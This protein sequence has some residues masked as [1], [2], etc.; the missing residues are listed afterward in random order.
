MDPQRVRAFASFFKNYMSVSAIVA[1]ALPIPVTS[2]HL[3]P[4]YSAHTS[5]LSTYTS[6]FC[7]LLLGFIF[8]SRHSLARWMFPDFFDRANQLKLGNSI[9]SFLPGALI[10]ASLA[11]LFSYHYLLGESIRCYRHWEDI[12]PKATSYIDWILTKSEL[13]Q[14]PWSGGV[15]ALY[16][17]IFVFA[18]SAFIMMAIREYLQDLA[19]LSEVEIIRGE[20]QKR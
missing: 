8:Y 4:T 14:I 17:G 2:L 13:W 15:M 10:V 6:L 9:V 3:I 5:L 20:K 16:L 11:S 7:F 19:N 1:A 18:E 12:D